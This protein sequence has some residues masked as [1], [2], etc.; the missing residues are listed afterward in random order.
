M[1]PTR[2]LVAALTGMLSLAGC[3]ADGTATTISSS[4]PSSSTT[5]VSAS[6]LPPVVECP[7]TGEFEE[8]RGI[9]DID[10]ESS[11]GSDLRRISWETTD[12]CETFSFDFE[13]SE[14]APAISVPDMRIDHLDTFQVIRIRMSIES[15][16]VTDQLVETALVDRLYVVKALD[17]TMYVDLHLSEPAAARARVESSPARLILDLKP[18]LVPFKGLSTLGD[19]I[20]V[21]SPARDSE[22]GL[23]PLLTGY[24]RTTDDDVLIVVTQDDV[25]DEAN[26][27]SAD[28]SVTWG[29][30]ETNVALPN[31]R[32]SMF[33]GQASPEDGSL[34]GVAFDVNA[35]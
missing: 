30:F 11:D 13:T 26:T 24:A 19:D 17:S 3:V 4:V 14:G 29:E 9:A 21:V 8:G 34:D 5:S 12:R 10:G 16:I 15:A 23:N 32:V 7:G 1:R 33:V 2:T 6:T 18:G 27:K 20:V 35:S 28:S 22:V 31:G 25:V